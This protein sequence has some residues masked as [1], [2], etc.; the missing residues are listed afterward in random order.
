MKL[1]NVINTLILLFS[2]PIIFAVDRGNNILIAI[3]AL[4]FFVYFYELD[5]K[6]YILFLSIAISIKIFP[7]LFILMIFFDKKYKDIVKIIFCTGIL[8]T[9][10]LLLFDQT[11]MFNI[12]S[13]I[14]NLLSF[15]NGYSVELV[16][17]TNNISIHGL[18]KTICMGINDWKMPF[19]SNIISLILNIT[20][21]FMLYLIL[22]N[23]K[24]Y[25][26]K[27][28]TI[29]LSIILIPS[30]SIEYNLVYLVVPMLCF[31]NKG[32]EEQSDFIY[33]VLLGL[34]FIPK[35]YIVLNYFLVNY[36]ISTQTIIDTMLMLG[37]VIYTAYINRS[38]IFEF[39]FTI[40]KQKDKFK[41][42]SNDI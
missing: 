10:P 23:E 19:Q 17:I 41:T 9:F 6:L 39:L 13:F 26:K 28:L 16:N 21:L 2:Y 14:H 29:T 4:Y 25:W 22:K 3:I 27:I 18:V 5:N 30:I 24:S 40:G 36:V 38:A 42:I 32:I 15:N 31:L 8:S 34:L 33:A 11:I 7:L 1:P 35:N 37:L 12:T 20:I